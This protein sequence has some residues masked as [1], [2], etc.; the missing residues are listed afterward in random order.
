MTEPADEGG[1]DVVDWVV[2]RLAA[3]RRPVGTERARTT[4]P[5]VEPVAPGPGATDGQADPTAPGTGR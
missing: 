1:H 2:G 3:S 5:T 4:D